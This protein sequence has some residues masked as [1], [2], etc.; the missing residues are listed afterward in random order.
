M[1]TPNY[2]QTSSTLWGPRLLAP[3]NTNDTIEASLHTLPRPLKRELNHVFDERNLPFDD[4]ADSSAEFLAVPTNQPSRRDLVGVGEDVEAEKDRLLNNFMH[5]GRDFCQQIRDSGYW[6]DYIDPCSGLPMLTRNC[7]K[8][9]SE[10][11]GMEACLGYRSY[12]AGFC[13]ILTHPKWGS[14]VYPAS[15]FVYAPRRVVMELL[16]SYP[17]AKNPN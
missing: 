10:V 16:Q 8:V 13:K 12:N 17:E 11:D 6:S 2:G 14:S 5:F 15:I 3:L 1:A 9:Y 4:I 7:N